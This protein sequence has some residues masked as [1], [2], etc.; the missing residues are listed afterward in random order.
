MNINN[1]ERNVSIKNPFEVFKQGL[2]IAEK[3]GVG[4]IHLSV[5]DGVIEDLIPYEE[6]RRDGNRIK[7]YNPVTNSID[8]YYKMDGLLY[9]LEDAYFDPNGGGD[10]YENILPSFKKFIG[11]QS[12]QEY[13]LLSEEDKAIFNDFTDLHWGYKVVHDRGIDENN[14]GYGTEHKRTYYFPVADMYITFSGYYSSYSGLE[15]S[16]FKETRPKEV[17]ITVYE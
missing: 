3:L 1:E 9:F 10:I 12:L 4:D 8:M 15:Y 17:Q 14:S 7:V 13:E 5:D 16:H 11:Y 6:R 2:K